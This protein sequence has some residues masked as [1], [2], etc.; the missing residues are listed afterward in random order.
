MILEDL[1]QRGILHHQEKIVHTY[2]FCWR[3]HTPLLYYAKP[4]WYIKTTAYR[5]QMVS[6]NRDI[7]WYPITSRMGASAIGGAQ[8]RL[9]PLPREIL[10]TPLPSGAAATIQPH[11]MC[12]R[13]QELRTK[14]A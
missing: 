14:P 10:G 13:L 8:H 3:C 7:N 5:D 1:E 9:G 2:P 4:S 6:G 12:W 11:G